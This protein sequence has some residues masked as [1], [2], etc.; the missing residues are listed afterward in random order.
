MNRFW[1]MWLAGWSLLVVLV[2]LGMVAVALPGA[3]PG[4]IWLFARLGEAPGEVTPALRE[5]AAVLGAVCIGWGASLAVVFRVLAQLPAVAARSAW[6]QLTGA[7]LLWFG[8]D[9]ACS[10]AFGFPGNAIGN[11]V[12]LL[13]FLVPA[14]A[15]QF[16]RPA[17]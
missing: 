4:Y 11:S 13:L 7:V 3:E 10:L 2:G 15:M 1:R 17:G 9:S 12:L 5:T 16:G 14:M 6:R 8:I